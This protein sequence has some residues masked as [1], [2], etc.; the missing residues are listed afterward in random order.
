[1]KERTDSDRIVKEYLDE[2]RDALAQISSRSAKEFVAE[3]E[4]H[5]AEARTDLDSGDEVGL[6]NLLERVGSPATLAG[7]LL[8]AESPRYVSFMD[9]ATPWLIALGG[10]AFGIGW[11]V[12]LYGLWS[13][14]TWRIWDK[15]LGTFLWPGGL[16]GTFYLIV[17]PTGSISCSRSQD[18][19]QS[20]TTTTCVHHG[21]FLALP[22]AFRLLVVFAILS[23][24]L[25]TSFRL[26]LVLSRGYADASKPRGVRLARPVLS[27]S[28]KQRVLWIIVGLGIFIFALLV[29][30]V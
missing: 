28:K 26:S 11:L 4:Q 30:G 29:L 15:L 7:E 1:M 24:P 9:R 12:G 2:L 22:L 10:F 3:I 19:G 14:K 21:F 8:E 27:K 5:I 16:F 18:V 6:R 17:A 20:A 23:A 25:F 13:S